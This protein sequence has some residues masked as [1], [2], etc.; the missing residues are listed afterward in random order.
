MKH[1]F[2]FLL[3][4]GCFLPVGCRS[5]SPADDVPCICGTPEADMQGCP[6]STCMHGK[7][8]PDNPDCVCGNL[9]IP[10]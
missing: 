10:R 5:S 1:L 6:H 4:V 3:A 8:N 2:P 9:S 7:R